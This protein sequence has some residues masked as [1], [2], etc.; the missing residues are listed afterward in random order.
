MINPWKIIWCD[1]TYRAF[2]FKMTVCLNLSIM[3]LAI[4]RHIK[5]KMRATLTNGY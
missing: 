1:E 5:R 4:M 3:F 2:Q